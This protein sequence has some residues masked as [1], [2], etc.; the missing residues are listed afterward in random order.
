MPPRSNIKAGR[1]GEV[2]AALFWAL[3]YWVTAGYMVL[4]PN[5]YLAYREVS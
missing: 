3:P 4:A 1:W 2:P 5:L